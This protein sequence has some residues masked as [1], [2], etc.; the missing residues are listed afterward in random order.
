MNIFADFNARVTKAVEALDLKD[1]DGATLDLSRIAV[2]PPR[3][4][5]HGDLATNAAMVLAKPTGQNPR[6]LAERLAAALRGNADIASAEIAGP[7]FVNLRLKDGFWQAHLAALLGEGRD[8]GRS[9]IGGGR[10]A[11]V[12]YV[13]ANPTGPMH[14]GHCR[15]AVVGD[16][17]AN[18]MAFA[19]YDVTKEYVINDAGSQIDVL[20]R[21]AMLRYR[22][23]LGEEIGEI[24][25][26]LYPGDYLIPVG[27]AL[28]SEFGRGLL[29]MPEEEALA[30]VKDRTVDAMMAM[31]R[32][33]LALLNVHHDVFFSERTLHGDNAKKIRAAIADLTLKGHIYKGKLPPPKGEKPDDWEDREQTLFRSTAVGDDMDRA[34]VKS[35][36]S[37]TYFAADVA[38]LKDK[39][40]RGFADL[41]YV[42]GADHGGYVK[43]LEALARAVAGDEVK[44]TVLL[45][46]LVKLFRD[47]EPVR[48]SK[49]SGDFVTLRDVV[50]EVGRDPIRFMMLYRKNDAPLD[51]DF[52]KVTEQSKDNPVFY[53]QYASARC[54]SVFRQA[55]EQL[56][57]ANF[58]RNRLVGSVSALT[59][60]G[61][62]GLIRKLA[63]YPRLIESA[64]L[65]LEPHRLAFYLHDLA[66]SFHAHWNRGT[67]NPDLRFVK[68][69]DRQLTYA[70][71]GLVQAVSD[72]LT[73]GLALIGA[74]APTEMR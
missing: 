14:V 3:D 50:E 24:P 30:I 54:H 20:G 22:Q 8:Y 37:F 11:N 39:V 53:V 68:V 42:L 16:T 43:R 21:S 17:L 5:S 49:R 40:E 2:E 70:R 15:G 41:I 74:D 55:S 61:E 19:G 56:D 27:Q 9:R 72:V 59:D 34:L 29:E 25:P 73:S 13:S 48:M 51:F 28:A 31:I 33:D 23:A 57:E 67:D 62:I 26:G 35:D 4:A 36:G 45:C 7:G 66:S 38:Y 60:E 64:A 10:K 12:E 52:A 18:L 63:E 32:E 69:N 44:L 58:D 71:L 6:V 1:K 65:A 47:G 46:Q